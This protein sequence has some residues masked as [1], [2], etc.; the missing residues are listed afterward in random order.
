MRPANIRGVA[1]T[2]SIKDDNQEINLY[3]IPNPHVDGMLLVHLPR[4]NV[5]WATDLVSPPDGCWSDTNSGIIRG[6]RGFSWQIRQSR[7]YRQPP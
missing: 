3:N 5:L 1:D 2:A 7:W 6:K 4:E